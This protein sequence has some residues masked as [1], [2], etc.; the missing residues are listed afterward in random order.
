MN[1]VTKKEYL[2]TLKSGAPQVEKAKDLIIFYSGS[3]ENPAVWEI[4]IA[5]ENL[6]RYVEAYTN[7]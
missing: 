5:L 2:K 6:V 1:L 4:L 7:E 3:R